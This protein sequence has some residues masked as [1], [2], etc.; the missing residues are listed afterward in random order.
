[1]TDLSK[2][3]SIPEAPD[4]D[5]AVAMT[6]DEVRRLLSGAPAVIRH[7]TSHLA[8]AAGKMIRARALLA[9]ALRKDGTIDPGAVKAA[10]GAELLHLATLVHDDI[11]DDADQRRGIAALHRKFGEKYAVLCG[12]WLFCA[13]LDLVAT[14]EPPEHRRDIADRSFTSYLTRVCL[15]ELRQNQN[16]GNYNLSEREYFKT[17]RGKT[18]ALFEACFYAGFMLSD[19]PGG[20]KDAYREIGGAI[21][22]IFQLADDCAD[23]EAT[24]LSAKKPVLSDFSRGVVTLPLIYALKNDAS[25]HDVIAAGL[26]PEALKDAVA[27]AGGLAYTHAKI[28]GLYK[29]TL[30]RI[31]SLDTGVYKK[32]LL[33]ALLVRASGR[34]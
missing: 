28:D 6:G 22:L 21:G 11:I 16:N 7:M 30:A 1:M 12:D 4:F 14:A 10:A 3:K 32:E 27:S 20:A 19:E 13:A 33:T 24:A 29:K 8:K 15:G 23:Y 9:C 17:I 26:G 2:D 31:K 25:L 5:S 18:A 34:A